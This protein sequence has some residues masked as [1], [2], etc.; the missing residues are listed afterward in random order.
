MLGTLQWPEDGALGFRNRG[1]SDRRYKGTLPGGDTMT[2]ADRAGL[3]AIKDTARRERWSAQ[4]LRSMIGIYKNGDDAKRR[5]VL[6]AIMRG[7]SKNASFK[8]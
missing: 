2:A 7:G 8:I 3:R 1:I 4:R 5:E 6:N